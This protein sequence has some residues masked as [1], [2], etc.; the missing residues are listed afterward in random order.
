M[1]PSFL[2]GS[3]LRPHSHSLNLRVLSPT[4]FAKIHSRAFSKY[5][6]LLNSDHHSQ[7]LPSHPQTPA[8]A[9]TTRMGKRKRTPNQ[10]PI[11]P[12]PAPAHAFPVTLED[13]TEC[14]A[15][16]EGLATVLFPR[17]VAKKDKSGNDLVDG[18]V[19]YNPVQQFNRDLSVL[20]I[21]AF[22]EV[23]LR[24]KKAKK[25]AKMKGDED[26][27][28]MKADIPPKFS[29]LDALSATGLRALR[30]ALE[31]PF[32]THTTSNDLD[33]S[34]SQS[35]RRNIHF[36]K[37]HTTKT[38]DPALTPDA[39]LS[40]IQSRDYPSSK[41]DVIDLD[42]FGTAVPFLD[43]A[44]Q[45]VSDGGLLCITCTDAGVWASMGYSE[46]CFSLYGGMPI[47]GEWSH[48]AG[49]RL[50]LYATATTAARYGFSIEPLL[51]LS[52]DFYARVFVRVRKSPREVKK[53]ASTSMIVYNCDSGCGSWRTQSLGKRK[54]EKNKNGDGTYL[55]FG[56]AMAPTTSSECPDCGFPMHLGGP[57]WSGP[58]HSPTFIT[59]LLSALPAQPPEIYQTLPRITGM[60]QTALQE[61]TLPNSPFFFVTNCLARTLHC[62]A[63][64]LA[65]FRGALM[66]LGYTVVR[67]HCK[68]TSV[69]TD[70]P[71]SL[72]WEVMRRWVRQKPAGQGKVGGAMAGYKILKF[73]I[74]ENADNGEGS[75]REKWRAEKEKEEMERLTALEI[76]FDEGLGK[77]KDRVKGVVRYQVN[78]TA[79]WGPLKRG[80]GVEA[81]IGET[82]AVEEGGG[83][84]LVERG[85]ESDEEGRVSKEAR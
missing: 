60:L 28:P 55:K 18:Q 53:L 43:A 65:A 50:I 19:F 23:F 24:E 6:T 14:T 36:N 22:G 13:G 37:T 76:V 39:A 46:K 12:N 4:G 21:R 17:F 31:I 26:E 67:S 7:K 35:I 84:E 27:R 44:V 68:P 73:G 33:P 34:A 49:L 54:E 47:K 62:E 38:V 1:T 32:V 52:I 85:E 71:W 41:Y 58:L 20:A 10:G 63:P 40:K 82:T 72:I 69:K 25:A 66:R 2:V 74:K 56:L 57:M 9:A 30:Y 75:A 11:A 70:A 79:N 59:H 8:P 42:P 48:E 78:P 15:V 83:G 77:D 64:P 45:A 3:T 5:S 81:L 51:S 16:R 80:R 29:I 61:S